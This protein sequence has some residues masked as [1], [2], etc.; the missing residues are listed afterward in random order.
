MLGEM[1][2]YIIKASEFFYIVVLFMLKRLIIHFLITFAW[3]LIV[4]SSD[5][6]MFQH[7]DDERQSVIR[8]KGLLELDNLTFVSSKFTARRLKV[9]DE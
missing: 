5:K 3:M 9:K 6:C 7:K 8:K 1:R 2:L 4:T